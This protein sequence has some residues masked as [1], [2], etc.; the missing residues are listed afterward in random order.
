MPEFEVVLILKGKE[1]AYWRFWSKGTTETEREKITRKYRQLSMTK[2]IK[3][4]TKTEAIKIV[5]DDHPGSTVDREATKAL[6]LR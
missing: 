2:L 6:R 5:L 4:K 1:Q 3:A